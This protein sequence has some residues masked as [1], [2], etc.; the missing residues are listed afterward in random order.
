MA[1]AGWDVYQPDRDAQG[2]E[3]AR[4]REARRDKA[5]A[6]RAAHEERRRE[7]AGEVRAQLWLAAGPSRLVR[8]AAARAGLRPADVLAQ[9]AERVVVDESG[10][11]SVPLFMPSW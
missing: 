6:A 1:E 11:V 2:S 7:E 10:K 5:L 9:L 4:E 3:W 8:A